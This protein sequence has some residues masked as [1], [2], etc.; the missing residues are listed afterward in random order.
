MQSVKGKKT[1]FQ[2][3]RNSTSRLKQPSLELLAVACSANA[4]LAGPDKSMD[5]SLIIKL[6]V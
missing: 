3:R 6:C 2:T 4:R 1:G 5:Q